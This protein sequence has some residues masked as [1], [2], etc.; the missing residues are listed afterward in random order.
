MKYYN[1]IKAYI[2]SSF[3][4]KEDIK[5]GI[6]RHGSKALSSGERL[7]SFGG[8]ILR[9]GLQFRIGPV[10]DDFYKLSVLPLTNTF[11][12]SRCSGSLTVY[13]Y[14]GTAYIF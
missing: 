10:G 4:R 14:P 5:A 2:E 8:D 7:S 13:H 6:E 3:D 9:P 11:L 12:R 1:K